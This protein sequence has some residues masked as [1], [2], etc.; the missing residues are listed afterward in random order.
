MIFVFQMLFD[1]LKFM[2]YCEELSYMINYS[3]L[4]SLNHEIGYSMHAHF[5][6]FQLKFAFSKIPL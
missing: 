2:K 3:D 5:L 1:D 4:K 6:P